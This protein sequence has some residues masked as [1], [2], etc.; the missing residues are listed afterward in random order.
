M[1]CA[2]TRPWLGLSGDGAG[3]DSAVEIVDCAD[4][5]DETGLASKAEKFAK[6]VDAFDAGAVRA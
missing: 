1:N 4:G 6:A 3:L 2:P 5:S